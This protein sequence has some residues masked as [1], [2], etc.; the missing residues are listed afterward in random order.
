MVR[1]L[2]EIDLR[3]LLFY[4]GTNGLVQGLGLWTYIM[5]YGRLGLRSIARLQGDGPELR[6]VAP[7]YGFLPTQLGFSAFHFLDYVRL[8]NF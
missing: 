8:Q 2:E 3:G 4:I 6:T 1:R 7:T 5:I